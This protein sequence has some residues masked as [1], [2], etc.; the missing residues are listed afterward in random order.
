MYIIVLL[1]LFAAVIS[2]FTI[3]KFYETYKTQIDQYMDLVRTQVKSVFK[4]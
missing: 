2:I 3:P 4:Q 1:P